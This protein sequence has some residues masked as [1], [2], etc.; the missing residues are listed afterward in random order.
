V[1]VGVAVLLLALW[2]FRQGER[3]V[4]WTL[5]LGGLPGFIAGIGV[6]ISV[7][8]LDLGHLFP[9]LV[10][11]VLFVLALIFAFPYLYYPEIPKGPDA[12]CL[13]LDN[14]NAVR[15]QIDYTDH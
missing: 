13:R 9:A 2:G 7:G 10:A 6:H 15:T 11:G 14:N 3:W 1:S 4:W 5:A 12:N 8:Y